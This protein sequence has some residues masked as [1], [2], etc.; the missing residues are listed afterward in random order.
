MMYLQNSA[1]PSLAIQ[2]VLSSFL[3]LESKRAPISI[4][5]LKIFLSMFS[6]SYRPPSESGE[7]DGGMV[8]IAVALTSDRT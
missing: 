6:L 8:M 3:Y 4:D 7:T 1:H 2:S 5:F